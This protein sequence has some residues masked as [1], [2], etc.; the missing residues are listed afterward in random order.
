MTPS[1]VKVMIVYFCVTVLVLLNSE[2][3]KYGCKTIIFI[4]L[5]HS[6]QWTIALPVGAT[7]P[8]KRPV[9]D[10]GRTGQ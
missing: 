7:G 3:M 8:A 10:T 6:I 2:G 9:Y 1:C 5:M 4:A